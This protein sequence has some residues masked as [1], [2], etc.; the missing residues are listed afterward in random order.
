MFKLCILV[1]EWPRYVPPNEGAPF[2]GKKIRT[3]TYHLN[4]QHMFHLMKKVSTTKT[5]TNLDL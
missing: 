5:W 3:N 2:A 4:N 1:K